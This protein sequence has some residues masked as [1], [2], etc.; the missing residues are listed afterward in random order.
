MHISTRGRYALR[1]MLDLALHADEGP[2]LRQDIA[3]RQGISAQ[4]IAQLFRR[5][6]AAGLVKGVRG[7]GGGY[8]LGCDAETVRVGDVLRAVEGPIATVHCVLPDDPTPCRRLDVCVIRLLWV[9]LSESIAEF[10]DSVTLRDLRDW[11]SASGISNT[12]PGLK[13]NSAPCTMH[14]SGMA[15][16]RRQPVRTGAYTYEI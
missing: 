1:A 5:L 3:A 2:V 7:P 8:V 10:L 12:L 6:A 14:S 11:V 13:A 9:Q 15:A 16:R 4:Y